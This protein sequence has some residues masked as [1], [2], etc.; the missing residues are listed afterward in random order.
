MLYHRATTAEGVITGLV[1]SFDNGGTWSAFGSSFSRATN[2]ANGFA[3]Q[4][5]VAVP[6]VLQPGQ[7]VLFGIAASGVGIIE[8]GCELTVRLESHRGVI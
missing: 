4:S 5:P 7:S 6:L 2:P 8:A 3:S 1:Y